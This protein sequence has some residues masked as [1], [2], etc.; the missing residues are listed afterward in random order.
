MIKA[1]LTGGIGS[2]K[3]YIADIFKALGIPVYDADNE[4]KRLMLQD[5]QLRD[6]ILEIFGEKAIEGGALNRR[7]MAD[8]LFNDSGKLEKVNKVVPEAVRKD[9][10]SWVNRQFKAPYVIQ[11]AA[12]HFET[13]SYKNFDYMIL[14]HAPE[15]TRI[16]RVMKRDNISRQSV[17]N[18]IKN[19]MKDD[20]KIRLSDFVISNDDGDIILD[21]VLKIHDN[22][23]SLHANG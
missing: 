23:I 15:S 16:E 2:G 13:G 3:S 10:T 14:V 12:I 5:N 4:A 21:Q 18:R 6:D 22:F 1:G 19:Q 7:Y 17:A 11:E 8:E 20:E 9:F